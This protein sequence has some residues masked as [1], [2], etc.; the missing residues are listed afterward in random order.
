MT[1]YRFT[2]FNDATT[3]LAGHADRFTTRAAYYRA[4]RAVWEAAEHSFN[5][6]TISCT[7]ADDLMSQ[8]VDAS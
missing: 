2:T 4:C 8:F 3:E 1:I 5:G 7:Q 6:A